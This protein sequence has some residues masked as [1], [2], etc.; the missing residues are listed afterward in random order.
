[1]IWKATMSDRK[2]VSV[3]FLRAA[4]FY[5]VLSSIGPFAT[6][7]LIAMGKAGTPL[8]FNSIYFYLHF[9]YNGWFSF[10]ILAVLASLLERRNNAVN[11]NKVFLL[12]NIA[13]APSFFLSILW[14]QPSLVYNIIGGVSA[15]L[16]LAAAF[17]LLNDLRKIRTEFSF[18]GKLLT[19]AMLAW[20]LKLIL[21]TFSAFPSIAHLAFENRN[22]IIAYL[23]LVLL[24]FISLAGLSLI[25][26]QTE[27]GPA[28]QMKFA[29]LGFMFSLVTTELLLIIEPTARLY[30]FYMRLF[31]QLMF[32]FSCFFPLA[33]FM[34]TTSVAR[35]HKMDMVR[36]AL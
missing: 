36:N 26:H 30:G 21:Q 32:F 33:I 3:K 10:V 1:V 11:T 13:C 8:Y 5:L 14:T 15:V 2:T 34:M 29:I 28:P 18:A 23:H 22:Y 24:G 31:P 20:I 19:I 35:R 9:Q 6:G 17:Y 4:C 7:P 12:M 25:L 27:R 16:Q